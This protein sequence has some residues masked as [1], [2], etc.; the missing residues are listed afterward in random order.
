MS[1]IMN[2]FPG[3]DRMLWIQAALAKLVVLDAPLDRS[4]ASIPPRERHRIVR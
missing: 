1:A 3:A 4:T 2:R